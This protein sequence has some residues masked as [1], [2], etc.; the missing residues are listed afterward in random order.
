MTFDQARVC[1]QWK[2][3]EWKYQKMSDVGGLTYR[4]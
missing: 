2:Y 4:F 1:V 3:R